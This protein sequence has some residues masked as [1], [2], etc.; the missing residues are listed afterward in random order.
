VPRSF[1]IDLRQFTLGR[2]IG[3]GKKL[4]ERKID[5]T[6]VISVLMDEG[7]TNFNEQR[8]YHRMHGHDFEG[9][10]EQIVAKL[11]GIPRDAYVTITASGKE[12]VHLLI[13]FD[14]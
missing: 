11:T 7:F 10:R 5:V 3:D 1:S 9:V 12:R 4:L 6:D 14:Y 8:I 13:A 2:P